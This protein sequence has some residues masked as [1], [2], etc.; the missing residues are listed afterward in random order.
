MKSLIRTWLATAALLVAA[1]T[2]PA[3][4]QI[5]PTKTVRLVVGASPGGTTDT[6]AR[7]IA[8]DMTKT[9]GQTVIVENKP[10]A[11]GNLAAQEVARSAADGHTLLV[12]FTSHTMNASLF[13]KL[14][15]DPVADFT[16]VALLAKVS[17]VLVARP[18]YPSKD[19]RD[20]IAK[21]KTDKKGL[22]LAIGGTGSSLH[23]D[24]YEFAT[25][26][27][28]S[29]VQVPFKGTSPALGDVM[30]GH[31]DFMFAPMGGAR[32]LLEAGKLR[33]YAVT[34]PKR[35]AALP[36]VPSITELIPSFTTNFGWFGVLGPSKLPAE[37]TGK[38]HAAIA[39]ALQSPKL[40]AR[41]ELDGSVPDG[42]GT[43][44]F[45]AFLQADLKHWA[46]QVKA[47]GIQP[48]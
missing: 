41:L 42:S 14:P 24:T 32:P 4:A 9:L 12:C 33:A 37:V 27:G 34:G 43:A 26:T 5:F 28:I 21:G 7:E 47:F 39:K 35:M 19:L 23:M 25:S 8:E 2:P 30:A 6:L 22:S 13:K 16:P 48:E 29:V 1:T 15:Y 40:K 31:I 10:G 45:T 3:L 20:L 44:E 46:S 18:D 38:L 36:D 11:G 17:S